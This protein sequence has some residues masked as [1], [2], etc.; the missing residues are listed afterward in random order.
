MATSWDGGD[1]FAGRD[2]T[3]TT[4]PYSGGRGCPER[5]D[6]ARW[7]GLVVTSGA[8][9]GFATTAAVYIRGKRSGW[10]D[11]AGRRSLAISVGPP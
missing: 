6:S 4:A 7:R 3:L 9:D 1:R 5:K 8:H 10:K 11:P 2:R